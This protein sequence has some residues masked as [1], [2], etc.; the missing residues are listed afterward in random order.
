[1]LKRYLDGLNAESRA[2]LFTGATGISVNEEVIS[3]DN[4]LLIVNGKTN[5]PVFVD[6][7]VRKM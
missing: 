4:S 3:Q 7:L 5:A 2:I 6:C 1:L